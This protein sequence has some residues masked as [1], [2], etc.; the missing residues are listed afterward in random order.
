MTLLTYNFS[1][2]PPR[3]YPEFFRRLLVLWLAS[4]PSCALST[5][6]TPSPPSSPLV[7]PSAPQ[8]RR[9]R[10]GA[11][12]HHSLSFHGTLS[13]SELSPSFSELSRYK[14]HRPP[15]RDSRPIMIRVMVRVTAL[16]PDPPTRMR[17]RNVEEQNE[18]SIAAFVVGWAGVNFACN[19]SRGF[20]WPE[21][22]RC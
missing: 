19:F 9:T 4:F 5:P 22:H 3:T 6:G 12:G 20:S 2:N 17:C 15:R 7:S 16:V 11:S 14:F 21:R 1:V 10:G 13:S 18:R 8:L